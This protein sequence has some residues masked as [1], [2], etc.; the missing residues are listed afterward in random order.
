VGGD[1]GEGAWEGGVGGGGAKFNGGV[2]WGDEWGGGGGG[3]GIG[4]GMALE[5]GWRGCGRKCSESLLAVDSPRISIY[6][7]RA[8]AKEQTNQTSEL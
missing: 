4:E 5:I 7:S 3:A 6:P 1:G 8:I 2:G